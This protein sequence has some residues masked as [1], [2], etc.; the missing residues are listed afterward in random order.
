MSEAMQSNPGK[1]LIR[2]VDGV[3]YMRIPIKT[4]LIT[5]EHNMKDVVDQYARELL[6]Q[7]DVLFISCCARGK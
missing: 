1:Q 3:D 4:H 7:G 2:T 6:G 5:H